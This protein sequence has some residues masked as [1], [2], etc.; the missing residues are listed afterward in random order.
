MSRFPVCLFSDQWL[1]LSLE[2]SEKKFYIREN[3]LA[4]AEGSL[5]G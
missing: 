3:V 5:E 4:A 2:L 1:N